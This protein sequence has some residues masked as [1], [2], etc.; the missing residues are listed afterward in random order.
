MSS[1]EEKGVEKG[2]R[3]KSIAWKDLRLRLEGEVPEIQDCPSQSVGDT[4]PVHTQQQY[5]G[6][7]RKYFYP[8]APRLEWSVRN[9][10]PGIKPFSEVE[11]AK[12]IE[13]LKSKDLSD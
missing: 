9:E 11:V 2:E 5:K 13:S 12:S 4:S 10:E 3:A 8:E 1:E 7:D 6:R